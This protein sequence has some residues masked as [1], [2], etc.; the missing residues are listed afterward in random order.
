MFILK[1][2]QI[3][4]ISFNT[5]YKLEFM[6]LHSKSTFLLK[7][8]KC[9]PFISK[10]IIW[11]NIQIDNKSEKLISDFRAMMTQLNLSKIYHR[12]LSE[13]S[14]TLNIILR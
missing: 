3:E 13:F 7:S 10:S 9:I 6:M 14:F 2:Y 4:M 5:N 8:K 12:L 1:T 11:N